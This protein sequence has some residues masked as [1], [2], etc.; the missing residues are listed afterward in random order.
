MD[1]N[2]I[3]I[4][5]FYDEKG[6]VDK[7]VDVLLSSIQ[8]VIQ[9]LVIV[10]NG[11]IEEESYI[12]LKKYTKDIFV[13]NNYGYDGGAYKDV[14]TKF[15][16]GEEWKY[17]D[18]IVLFNDTFYAP[19]YSWEDVFESMNSD[20]LDFWG[21]SRHPGGGRKLSTGKDIPSHIQGYFVVCKSTLFLSLPWKKFWKNLVYPTSYWDAVEKFEI[22]F[23]TYFINHGFYAGAY[24][25]K[26]KIKMEK[27]EN[28]YTHYIEEL[29]KNYKFPVIK[30]KVICLEHLT[31]AKKTLKY[32]KENT[33]YNINLICDH[34]QRLYRQGRVNPIAPFNALQ[35]EQFYHTHNRIFIYGHG[36]YGKGISE[37]FEYKN[38]KYEAFI[39]SERKELDE[40]VV[41]YQNMKFML[42][43]GIVLALGKEA[44][45]EVYLKVKNDLP[46]DQLCYPLYDL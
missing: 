43:D 20:N 8:K 32:I 37:Y 26:T 15:L 40:D 2:R 45:S 31:E 19:L 41:V 22:Y 34:I 7:Y 16:I 4:F 25:D 33:N 36:A 12:N 38:W 24:T 46:D 6:H 11:Q 18:E 10:V 1:V 13:R 42:K 23:T 35:L 39:V 14:L 44:F 9:K 5:A 3:G 30:R 29:V 17:W 21:L 28:P 27:G